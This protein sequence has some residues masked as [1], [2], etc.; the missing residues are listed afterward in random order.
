MRAADRP[1][2]KTWS[3]SRPFAASMVITWTAGA[4]GHAGGLLLAQPRLGDRGEVAR[5]VARRGVR[6]AAHVGRGQLGELRDV[7]QPLDRV[8]V[9]GEHLLAA[10]ADALDQPQHEGVG[11]P[12]LERVRGRAVEAQE[13]AR[14]VAALLG[15]L[16]PLER[17][18]HGRGH[19]ELAPARELR[20]ASHVHR[21]QLD[22][23]PLSARTTAP[24]SFGSASARSQAST[25]RTSARWK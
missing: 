11:P 25:S 7:A 3:N 8:R 23:R 2:T 5:E 13:R 24:E 1:S 16:R 10:Q 6:L 17:R 20:Q 19:V 4:V 15:E 14:A 18:G 9:G 22:G 21:A 12:V